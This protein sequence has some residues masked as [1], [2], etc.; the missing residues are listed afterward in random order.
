MPARL[1]TIADVHARDISATELTAGVPLRHE[2]MRLWPEGISGSWKL[3][4]REVAPRFQLSDEEI[5]DWEVSDLD[6]LILVQLPGTVEFWVS[7]AISIL[8]SAASYLL[9]PK[10]RRNQ[11]NTAAEDMESATNQLAGQ[12]NLLRPGARVPDILGRM[13]VYPDLLTNPLAQWFWPQTQVIDQFF[14]VGVGRYEASE[15]QLGETPV[16]SIAG[17]SPTFYRP[18]LLADDGSTTLP[19]D[20]VPM[21]RA[22]R[23]SP[24]VDN[25]S[26]DAVTSGGDVPAAGV[27]FNAAA[28]TL[29]SP[30]AL[31]LTNDR[32]I[33]VGPSSINAGDYWVVGVPD[34]SQTIGPFVYQLVGPVLDEVN[35]SPTITM[36]AGYTSDPAGPIDAGGASLTYWQ[37]LGTGTPGPFGFPVSVRL[38]NPYTG[39]RWYAYATG[40]T[41]LYDEPTTIISSSSL[42]L[43]NNFA[44]RAPVNITPGWA[45]YDG[46]TFHPTNLLMFY[47][48]PATVSVLGAPLAAPPPPIWTSRYTVPIPSPD[49]IWIDVAFAQGLIAYDNGTSKAFVVNVSAE[50]RRQGVPGTEV[51]VPLQAFSG[52]KTQY[53]RR[54]DVFEVAGTDLHYVGPD[55]H[56]TLPGSGPIEVR[57]KRD[58]AIP[59]E[60]ATH[61]YVTSCAWA[62]LIGI[63]RLPERLYPDVT[64]ARLRLQNTRSASSLG[65]NAF[66][67]VAQRVL[68]H[69][70]GTAWSTPAA[71]T[72]WAD[73]FVARCKAQ[74]GANLPDTL[75]D[76]G[77]IYSLQSSLDAMDSAQQGRISMALDQ[78]QDIDAELAQIADVVR[79]RVY[80]VGRKVYVARDQKTTQRIALFNGRAKS[81]DAESQ[82]IRLKSTNDADAVIVQWLDTASGWKWREYQYPE[83]IA[84]ANPL[85]IGA[86]N[87]NWAQAWRRARYEWE[88]ISYQRETMTC[89]VTEDGRICRPGDVINMTDD[90]A[91]LSLAAGEIIRID[92]TVLTLD[93]P[94]DSF[95]TNPTI[96]LRDLEGVDVDAIPVT[97]VAGSPDKVQLA[98]APIATVVIKARDEA[99]GSLYAFYNDAR[100]SVR[101]WMLT[102]VQTN[103]PYVQV[104]GVNYTDRVYQGDIDALPA[105]P[106][107]VTAGGVLLPRG[108]A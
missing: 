97:A 79:A 100:A 43:G 61:Q 91:N 47:L 34:P 90:V 2:L 5:A 3:Y 106:A 94:I 7:F 22:S 101:P 98:R 62:S 39:T 15:V 9:A 55:V 46:Y 88:R 28:K 89:S 86:L 30:T 38:I 48:D 57:L 70:T 20:V 6:V 10:P 80:R 8:L 64:I 45:W 73:H 18:A 32:P 83:S 59:V 11:K 102:A 60:D 24:A 95:G 74:D 84:P 44:T 27:T 4:A 35:V 81:A 67:L 23:S 68:P 56:Y 82:Q 85:R 92:G 72:S 49:E 19:G 14:A 87:A 41:Y 26:L 99:L 37:Q 51:S 16:T 54:T 104:S 40:V 42:D 21:I 107:I 29:S 76:L 78:V 65:E 13:R 93:Q 53:M 12:S 105:P 77:G 69:W 17:N 66:N 108:I 36:W 33:R 58:T 52:Q 1:I 103:G 75:I 71:T 31:G 25:I 63:R 50:F 96:L